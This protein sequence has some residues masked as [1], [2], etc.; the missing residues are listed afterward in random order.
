MTEPTP[1][2][3]EPW[4][5]ERIAR[6]RPQL[7]PLAGLHALL[8]ETTARVVAGQG[9]ANFHPRHPGTP[10]VH[11]VLGTPLF[12]ACDQRALLAP[13]ITLFGALAATLSDAFPDTAPA[14]S[15]LRAA[16][17]RTDFPWTR[18]V[19]KFRDGLAAGAVPHAGL[20]RFLLWRALAA[21]LSH[22]AAATSPPHPDRWKRPACPYCGLAPV[23]QI[24]EPGSSRHFLCVLCG[25]DW[26][27]ADLACAAC[28]DD[29]LDQWLV[30]A[31]RDLGPATLEA[32]GTCRT[33][34]KVLPRALLIPGAPVA[35]EIL[36]VGLDLLAREQEGVE[37]EQAPL[38]AVFPPP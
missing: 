20:F 5:F 2:T 25:G 23:V 29:R 28:G 3:D 6:E 31:Q 26:R 11:W 12:D 36:T 32:C 30:V 34:V 18:H 4:T 8:A 35:L 14:L 22:L 27:T 24:A 38:A 9:V 17:S 37:R 33:A 16:V 15:E 1:S 10:A 19:A 13:T 21:P 7:A